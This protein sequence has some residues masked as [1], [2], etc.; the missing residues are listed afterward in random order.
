MKELS[1][2]IRQVIV[3]A[4][5]VR[6]EDDRALVPLLHSQDAKLELLHQR[7]YQNYLLLSQKSDS[8]ENLPQINPGVIDQVR[9]GTTSRESRNRKKTGFFSR[10]FK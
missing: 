2:S 10:Y 9:D 6:Q 4:I 3:T 5:A 7:L 1:E 8:L